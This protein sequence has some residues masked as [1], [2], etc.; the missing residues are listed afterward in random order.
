[1]RERR[2]MV[3]QIPAGGEIGIAGAEAHH[4]I[5]V[6]RLRA[7]EEVALFDGKGNACRAMLTHVGR[8]AATAKRLEALPSRE[9]ALD[10]TIAITIPKGEAMSLIVRKLTELGVRRIVPLSTDRSRP[11]SEAALARRLPRWR[12]IA[13]EA[14]KQSGRSQLTRIEPRL[15]FSELLNMDLPAGRFL[16]SPGGG[17]LASS[18]AGSS[19]FAAI[20]PEGGWTQE[21][22]SRALAAGFRRLGLG[23][24]TL[25]TETAALAAAVVLQWAWG[26][27]QG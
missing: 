22:E 20:G 14:C 3:P 2:F 5:H 10:L 6:L 9:S 25:R 7:G 13:L 23:P 26:D 11:G 24:R 19:C 17:P 21:E 4:L 8:S 15:T 18:P 27:L 16:L 12:R 1:M